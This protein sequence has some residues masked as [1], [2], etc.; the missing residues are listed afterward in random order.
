M[1]KYITHL[2]KLENNNIFG[3][4]GIYCYPFTV[5]RV[6]SFVSLTLFPS[7]LSFCLPHL[8]LSLSSPTISLPLSSK[9]YFPIIREDEQQVGNDNGR[10]ITNY[11]DRHTM[12]KL[13]LFSLFKLAS[14]WWGC[15]MAS[16]LGMIFFTCEMQ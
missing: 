10:T 1:M 3:F 12:A 5:N 9:L 7:F 13:S 15:N 8:A 14:S 4:K 6:F 16:F 2:Q 11:Q